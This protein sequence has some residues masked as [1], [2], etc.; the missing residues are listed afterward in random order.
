MRENG[1]TIDILGLGIATVDDLLFVPFFP[2]PDTK[3]QILRSERHGGGLT[4]TALVAAARLGAHCAYAGV[5]G[6]DPISDWIAADLQAEGV[7]TA[8][9]PRR[10]EAQ[11]VHAVIVVDTQAQT[12]TI[13]YEMNGKTGADDTLPEAAVIQAARVLFLDDFGLEGNRRAA[14]IARAAGV[15][16]VADFEFTDAPDLLALVNHLIVSAAY[17][18]RMTGQSDPAAAVRALWAEGRSAVVVTAGVEGCWY[19][20]GGVVGHQP[21]FRVQTVDTTGCGDVF[22]G[23]YAWA[24]ARGLPLAER[25][26]YASGAAAL[27]A[28][29]A[30]GRAGIPTLPQLEAFL[31][32]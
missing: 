9:L 12:R 15:P 18:Q 24:L 30:G 17:A 6:D 14:A 13:L 7:D 27:K 16:V 26:R 4:A 21:A 29:R 8:Y 11:P 1:M 23:A 5:L 10:A 2:A 19:S 25:V 32:S 3:M 28:T 20:E 31:R 22:H